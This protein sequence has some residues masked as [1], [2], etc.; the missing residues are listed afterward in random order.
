[1]TEI[2]NI[3]NFIKDTEG[4]KNVTR[5]AWTSE[6]KRESVAEHSWRLAVFALSLAEY[7]PEADMGKV[8][9]MCII[10]DFGEIYE[11]DVSAKFESDPDGKLKREADAVSTLVKDL[12]QKLWTSWRQ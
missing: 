9:G 10:H 11:G 8:L 2:Y 7:F 3:L 12:P 1:M 5:T 4:L 6:G